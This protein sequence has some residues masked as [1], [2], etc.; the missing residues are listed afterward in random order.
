TEGYVRMRV[1]MRYAQFSN[2]EPTPCGTWTYG[3][4]EDYCVTLAPATIG[5]EENTA[6]SSW[7]VYPNP[8]H[9]VIYFNHPAMTVKEVAVYDQ[10][11]RMVLHES[12]SVFNKISIETLQPGVYSLMLRSEDGV[13]ISKIVKL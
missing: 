10:Q 7:K 2:T 13:H 12:A 8:A 9:D 3:E 1:A 5:I 6:M 4:V 11:G